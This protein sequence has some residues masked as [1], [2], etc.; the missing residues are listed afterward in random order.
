MGIKSGGARSVAGAIA[1]IAWL[2]LAVQS[3]ATMAQTGSIAETLWVLLRYFTIMTN[4]LAAIVLTG[5][6]SGKSTSGAPFVLGGT[7]LAMVF[8]GIIYF[9]F[10]RGLLDL[11][12]R[13]RLADFILHYV[14]PAL[15]FLFWIVFAPKGALRNG[16]PWLW[17]I[18]PLAY[19][20]YALARGAVEHK[21][22]YPFIDVAQMGWRQ[23]A[24]NVL[25][26][27]L[28]FLAAGFAMVWLERMM[29]RRKPA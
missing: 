6:A 18:Y 27:T 13:A 10:L 15:V 24:T 17:V 4:L 19:A 2:G 16:D 22:A 25:L 28:S 23:V 12:G 8:V 9:L 5:I 29:G 20:V 1:L 21:Y 7:T 3:S 26:L 14:T 11:S